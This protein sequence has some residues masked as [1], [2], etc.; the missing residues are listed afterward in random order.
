MVRL[1]ES[2]LLHTDGSNW[3]TQEIVG[4]PPHLW[5]L[6]MLQQHQV[7]QDLAGCPQQKQYVPGS[8]LLFVQ[9]GT[10]LLSL[11][12]LHWTA[13]EAPLGAVLD[14]HGMWVQTQ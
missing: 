5:A 10:C 4:A 1:F 2:S 13:S 14:V 3:L 8:A 12:G 7:S 11:L 9:I 6:G